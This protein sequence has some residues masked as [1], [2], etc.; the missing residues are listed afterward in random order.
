MTCPLLPVALAATVAL[1]T[2]ALARQGQATVLKPAQSVITVTGVPVSGATRS[3]KVTRITSGPV[4][5]GPAGP[6][7]VG[8]LFRGEDEGEVPAAAAPPEVPK[9]PVDPKRIQQF[10]QAVLDRTPSTILSEW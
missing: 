4:S 8:Q 10:Q 3:G 7:S 5:F 1:S 2:P 9:V 6:D